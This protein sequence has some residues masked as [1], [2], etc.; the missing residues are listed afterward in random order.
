MEPT[1]HLQKNSNP[2]SR[3]CGPS[4]FT[5]VLSE[6]SQYELPRVPG[7]ICIVNFRSGVIEEGMVGIVAD[8]FER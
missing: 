6:V 8:H 2:A 7:S 4:G 1:T 3:A 5:H